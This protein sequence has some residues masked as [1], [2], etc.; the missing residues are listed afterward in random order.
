MTLHF[1]NKYGKSRALPNMLLPVSQGGISPKGSFWS[2][3]AITIFGGLW[4]WFSVPETGG[5]TLE[6]MDPI[7]SIELIK[8]RNGCIEINYF[9]E[10][11]VAELAIY[12]IQMGYFRCEMNINAT[13]NLSLYSHY[14]YVD[15]AVVRV[16]AGIVPESICRRRAITLSYRLGLRVGRGDCEGSEGKGHG[17]DSSEELHVHG[18]SGLRL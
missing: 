12:S 15:L 5:R 7:K 10:P 8:Y 1:V 18:C 14:R 6:S 2:F 9:K 13:S 4:V 17:R 3:A 16:T 11:W